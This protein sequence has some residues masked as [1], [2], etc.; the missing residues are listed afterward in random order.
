MIAC[1]MLMHLSWLKSTLWL[2]C[3]LDKL[4]CCGSFARIT[5]KL[6]Y[7]NLLYV[8][9]LPFPFDSVL[10]T[11]CSLCKILYDP[12]T[13]TR[14]QQHLLYKQLPPPAAIVKE[15]TQT[16]TFHLNHNKCKLIHNPWS[17]TNASWDAFSF[18]VCCLYGLF[19]RK[20]GHPVLCYNVV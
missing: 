12:I 15:C 10:A 13:I 17:Y 7:G 1:H 16:T 19:K 3:T 6:N 8:F 9:P 18:V 11:R 20:V 5:H 2:H 14:S 4:G